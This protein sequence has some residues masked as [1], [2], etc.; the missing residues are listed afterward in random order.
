[1]IAHGVP[2][3]KDDLAWAKSQTVAPDCSQV[4]VG[5]SQNH[6]WGWLFWYCNATDK[7][8]TV[9]LTS[10]KTGSVSPN[11]LY[12][13]CW[14]K[15]FFSHSF[16]EPN[17]EIIRTVINYYKTVSDTFFGQYEFNNLLLF[18]QTMCETGRHCSIEGSSRND[19]FT[20]VMC[21]NI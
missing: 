2:A 10:L 7:R 20:W 5:M 18:I 15:V 17:I 14:L 13:K 16:S 3:G 12:F 9:H 19:T 21:N 6:A 1:M 8:P 11:I 4:L